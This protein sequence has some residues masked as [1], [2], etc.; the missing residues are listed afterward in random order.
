VRAGRREEKESRGGTKGEWVE[1]TGRKWA[2]EEVCTVWGK[3][4]ADE[5]AG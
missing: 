3:K 1:T 2:K 5:L 4:K